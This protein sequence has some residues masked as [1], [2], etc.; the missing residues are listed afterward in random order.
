MRNWIWLICGC[1]LWACTSPPIQVDLD[2]PD[3]VD[4][5]P[6]PESNAITWPKVELGR[7]LFYEEALSLDSSVSCASCH[8]QQFAFADTARVSRG[9]QRDTGFRNATSLTNVAFQTAFFRDGGVH[10]LERAVHPPVLTEFE[11]NMDIM[12]MTSRLNSNPL[13]VE[14]FKK[15]YKRPIDYKGIVEALATFQRTLLSFQSPYDFYLQG[16][17]L[18]LNA[19]AKRGL[20]LFRSDRLA[21]AK[22]HVEPLFI[23]NDMHNIGVYEVYADYGRG[24]VTLDSADFGRFRT[25][26][27]RNISVTFP[28][29]HDGSIATLQEVIQLYADGGADHPNKSSL[30]H[31]F[32]LTGDE[33][34]DLLAFLN[35]LT[36]QQFLTNETLSDPA[37]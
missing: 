20:E 22:C 3:Y 27:L 31:P 17:E 12:K 19:S 15:A 35:A 25:P 7:H 26:T 34:T 28:Y 4:A 1:S 13:Y 8:I 18:A 2:L 23:D 16:D 24:R 21:C 32:E 30:I 33:M 29:M 36:D 11:M 6:V 5:F 37:N 10:S 14:L 9:F